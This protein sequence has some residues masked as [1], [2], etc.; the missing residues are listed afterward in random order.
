MPV[1]EKETTNNM[2]FTSIAF[3]STKMFDKWKVKIKRNIV[4]YRVSIKQL[5]NFN[6]NQ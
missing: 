6:T 4:L 5:L 3:R 1:Y 2:S